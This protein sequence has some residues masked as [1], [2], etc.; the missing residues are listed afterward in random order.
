MAAKLLT[1]AIPTY[2]RAPTLSLLLETLVAEISGFEDSIDVLI[3]DNASSDATPEVMARFQRAWPAARLIRH[4]ANLGVDENFCRCIEGACGRYFWLLGDDDLPGVGL[5]SRLLSLIE[6]ESPDMIYLQSQWSRELTPALQQA[7]TAPLVY[8]R[9]GQLDFAK[10]VHVWFTFIS[11]MVVN[12]DCLMREDGAA[13]I[14]RFPATNLVQL[15]WV[16]EILRRGRRYIYVSSPCILA[17]GGNSGGYALVT[18]FGRNLTNIV[19]QVFGEDSSIA[20]VIIRRNIV[21]YLPRLIWSARFTSIG[22][23]KFQQEDFW[24]DLKGALANNIYFWLILTPI[25]LAPKLMALPF[26]VV[27]ILSSI[28][29]R[30]ADRLS[31]RFGSKQDRESARK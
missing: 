17:K 13:A 12:R 3:C 20:K 6:Q 11:G 1:I 5:I 29:L 14:R 10:H 19:H 7:V 21:S 18:V 28:F 25:S 30:Q 16:L 22:V 31:F 15:G 4:P 9:M 8:S 2:N 26:L 23:E 27:S 24:M